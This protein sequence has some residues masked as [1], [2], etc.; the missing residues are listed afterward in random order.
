M[1]RKA[2][3]AANKTQASDAPEE[4]G[5]WKLGRKLGSGAFSSVYEANL[6]PSSGS[7]LLSTE[8]N[9][10]VL[11][12]APV[13]AAKAKKSKNDQASAANLVS[14]ENTIYRTM[15]Q[16]HD[17]ENR[18]LKP[19][20]KKFLPIP[21]MPS[22]SQ[23]A[24]QYIPGGW[25]FLAIERLGAS[26]SEKIK[27]CKGQVP[28]ETA[29]NVAAQLLRGL[30]FVHKFGFVFRDV[31]PDNFMLGRVEGSENSLYLVDFGAAC[32]ERNY[33]G[34]RVPQAPMGT[35]LYMSTRI[36]NSEP[37]CFRDDLESLA[38]IL[39]EM[40]TSTLPWANAKSEEEIL[41]GKTSST[42]KELCASI[43]P[44]KIHDAAENFLKSV[45]ALGENDKVPYDDLFSTLTGPLKSVT[46]DD[47]LRQQK[48]SWTC[49][50]ENSN[51]DERAAEDSE[52]EV[53]LTA[54]GGRKKASRTNK[55]SMKTSEKPK[56]KPPTI[57]E[58]VDLSSDL[59]KSSTSDRNDR[60]EPKVATSKRRCGELSF[61]HDV[62]KPDPRRK[63]SKKEHV[64]IAEKSANTRERVPSKKNSRR[65]TKDENTSDN[66]ENKDSSN[67]GP[68]ATRRMTR[69][70][71][72]SLPNAKRRKT[73]DN[74]TKSMADRFSKGTAS[75]ARVR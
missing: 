54:N 6:H 32:K 28:G 71:T 67:C 18:K 37:P 61:Q 62:S 15:M 74:N 12:T 16:Q 59:D 57:P 41:D 8:T 35:P 5:P 23:A 29:L 58:V 3:P 63:K 38:Y 70:M 51:K 24:F 17:F 7:K 21:R 69:S 20:L 49:A 55:R 9:E 11:K 48:L 50:G 75:A 47:A 33:Q 60:E 43:K 1:P 73:S 53:S 46:S 65:S 25:C 4:L 31:K 45:L 22:N 13:P 68:N 64:S 56:I 30:E 10:W 40:L 66:A 44:K 72:N 36:H 39:V 26:L 42:P 2:A 52:D 34:A 27:A 19:D 14:L